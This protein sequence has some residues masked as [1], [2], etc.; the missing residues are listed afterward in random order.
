MI[1]NFAAAE[2]ALLQQEVVGVPMP[3]FLRKETSSRAKG[4]GTETNSSEGVSMTSSR[5]KRYGTD[6]NSSEG[7]SRTSFRS[8]GCGTDTNSS[9]GH[10]EPAIALPESNA[11]VREEENCEKNAFKWM[12]QRSDGDSR[13]WTKSRTPLACPLTQLPISLLPY[14][15]FKLCVNPQKPSPRKLVDGKY[16]ALQI[17]VNGQYRG[18]RPPAAAV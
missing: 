2:E 15:P 18:M 7:V 1:L 9:E 3:K 14:P 17:I 11:G 4:C 5:A 6:T 16:L 8:K 10:M 13:W 12:Q